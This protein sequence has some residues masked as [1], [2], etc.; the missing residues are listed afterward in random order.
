MK[1]ED[2][3]AGTVDVV[4]LGLVAQDGQAGLE[5]GRLDVGDQTPT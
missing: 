4:A 5:V 1:F 2:V 3:S